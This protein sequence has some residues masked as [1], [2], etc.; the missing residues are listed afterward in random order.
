VTDLEIG[1]GVVVHHMR[2]CGFCE[3]C[4]AGI[5]QH[6]E[7]YKRGDIGM[8]RGCGFD[9]GLAEF[10]VVPRT[11]IISIGK[12]DPILY[13]PLTDAGVTAYAGLKG[14]IS[15]LR[16]GNSVAVIGVGGLGAY[17][18]QFLKVLTSALVIAVDNVESRL[19]MATDLG[20]DAWVISDVNAETSIRK[21][22]GG[23]GVDA[24]LDLVG[25]DQTLQLAAK[26]IRPQGYISVVG[27]QGGSVRL[28]WNLMATSS[29]FALSLG[30]TRKDLREVCQLATDGKLRIDID[31]FDFDEIPLAY[32]KLKK[33]QLKGRAV[34]V[35]P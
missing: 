7:Y 16:P 11:E 23:K 22:T 12:G 20:A 5:E 10:L 19:K 9:G 24:I 27:M 14:F 26:V 3:F 15:Q 21:I 25:S 30:S 32:E 8:T 31:R 1:E 35:M 4:E 29:K 17:A 2:H 13:A 34:I 28:G 33:G 18:V 6:C